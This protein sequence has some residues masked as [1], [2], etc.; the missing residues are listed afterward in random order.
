MLCFYI[1]LIYL[2]SCLVSFYVILEMAVLYVPRLLRFVILYGLEELAV[3]DHGFLLDVI[4]VLADPV[5]RANDLLV[6]SLIVCGQCTYDKIVV[7][8]SLLCTRGTRCC[9]PGTLRWNRR[10]LPH[11]PASASPARQCHPHLS[12]EPPEP[13]LQVPAHIR[14]PRVHVY[15]QASDSH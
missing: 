2:H 12:S 11:T 15:P 7:R 3:L 1:M 14:T 6:E 4:Q 10:C 9:V 13:P 8:K 5:Q